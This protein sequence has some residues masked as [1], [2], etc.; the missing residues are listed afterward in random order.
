MKQ[1]LPMYEF[2]RFYFHCTGNVLFCIS[3]HV[4]EA[5]STNVLF[6]Y[7][8]VHSNTVFH[9]VN[10]SVFEQIEWAS[11]STV[12]SDGLTCFVSFD[13][14]VLKESFDLNV[15]VSHLF[16]QG[17]A[18]TYWWFYCHIYLSMTDLNQPRCQHKNTFIFKYFLLS[19]LTKIPLFQAPEGKKNL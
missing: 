13:I 18:A 15:S 5:A 14:S 4:R 19:I 17:L 8:T 16:K 2:L 11:D 9:S 6:V 12:H 7:T 1:E 10:E 3:A